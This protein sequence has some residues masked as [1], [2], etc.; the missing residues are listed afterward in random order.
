MPSATQN[1]FILIYLC[2]LIAYGYGDGENTPEPTCGIGMFDCGHHNC[3][4]RSWRCDGDVDCL[5]GADEKSCSAAPTVQCDPETHYQCK[6]SPGGSVKPRARIFA[7]TF[8]VSC[9]PHAWKCDGEVDCPEKDDEL[10]CSP[11]EV[12]CGDGQFKCPGYQHHQTSCIPNSW[13]CDGESDCVDMADE[14]NCTDKTVLTLGGIL[15]AK[16][17]NCSADEFQCADGTCIFGIWKCDGESDC[18]DNSDED[19]KLCKTN[20]TCDP[21]THFQ[22]ADNHFCLPMSWRCDSQ[23]D[24]P[25]HSD[26]RNC[27]EVKRM[28][29]VKC[30][31][32]EWQCKN[33]AECIRSNWRC[34]L[35]N[36]C[37]DGSDEED[38]SNSELTC[39]V[40]ETLCDDGI[41]RV[42]CA[43]VKP[44]LGCDDDREYACDNSTC[45][46]L[47]K[48]CSDNSSANNCIKSV[49]AQKIHRCDN[50][51]PHC[52]CRTTHL[53]GE[54]CYCPP[55]FERRGEQCVD[56]D[57]CQQPGVCD[58]K[59]VN[60]VGSFK[61]DCYHGFKLTGG[62]VVDGESVAKDASKCRAIGND[63]LLLL[64]NRAMIRQFDI[65][66]NRYHP[67]V[68]KLESAVAMDYWH[69]N[70]TLIWSDVSKEQIMICHINVSTDNVIGC[71]EGGN[72]TL[73]SKNVSTPDGLAID[74]VHGLLFWTDTGLDT[75]N[76]F[77]LNTQ[78]R[79]VL[80]DTGL[81][82]PRAIAVDPSAGLIFWT[83]WG[84]RGR[85]ERAGMDGQN[86]IEI[87]NGDTVR[88]PNGLAV[89]IYDQR[90]YWADAK[91]KAIS[92]CDYWGKNVRTVLHSHKHLRHP[93][94]V[95]VFEERIY[96]TD[97]DHEGVL[98]ANKFTGEDVKTVMSGVTGPMT[99]RIYHQMAQPDQTNKCQMHQCQHLCLPKAHIREATAEVEGVLQGLPYT[100]GC[101]IG[102][103]SSLMDITQCTPEGLLGE[104][105][106]QEVT[107]AGTASDNFLFGFFVIGLVVSAVLIGGYIYR[108][109]RFSRFTALQFDNPIYRRT[110]EDVEGELEIFGDNSVGAIPA[111]QEPRLVLSHSANGAANGIA[112]GH[113]GPPPYGV[114]HDPLND[115]R[116][117]Y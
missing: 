34:D 28:H 51:N 78:K 27:T 103:R 45:I 12:H 97:W 58:Q 48:L 40:D 90:V 114:S 85:I 99:V 5:N 36:D 17:P 38:C 65:V 56:I 26:E 71:I 11:A 7:Q 111:N 113:G 46:N 62:T 59:C 43:P 19:M 94:S 53:G 68:S 3:I 54:V 14:K 52:K 21:T 116:G 96:W 35:D 89:D 80:F 23:P 73:I 50:K 72:L 18:K 41:C 2:S 42:D 106:R 29:E 101:D 82:E 91:I 107:G 10:G 104:V 77:D 112:N 98:T 25:D 95:A 87:L 47:D 37:T 92:S 79:K 93:F 22:C 60:L 63:P 13:V 57:E 67:L 15:S 24:C 83:D 20:N 16:K 86:R 30:A 84:A 76:V 108:Q 110:V 32:D 88:W 1:L 81:E 6:P 74:W 44:H 31:G 69:Q 4:P 102:F 117:I 109:R 9:I 61:C 75:V 39:G 8:P 64:S 55:G 100:C 70:R 115:N 49:C 105:I 33:K 66:N